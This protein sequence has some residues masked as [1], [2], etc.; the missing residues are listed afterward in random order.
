[1][2]PPKTGNR[3]VEVSTDLLTRGYAV[4]FRATG[5]S[6][7]PAICDGDLITVTPTEKTHLSR[8]RI[9]MYRRH[10]RL[11]AHRIVDAAI[12]SVSDELLLRGD[13]SPVC[14]PL[15]DASQVLGEVVSVARS[16]WRRVV[17][18]LKIRSL[19]VWD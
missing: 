19:K 6:M 17:R 3:F 16:R 11:V 7:C 18:E 10:D 2:Q 13:A 1:M 5:G 12:D 4:R 14:D 15:V 8:G 9:V